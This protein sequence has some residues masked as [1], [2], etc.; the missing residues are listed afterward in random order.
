MAIHPPQDDILVRVQQR[1]AQRGITGAEAAS[2]VAK[3]EA[4]LGRVSGPGAGMQRAVGQPSIP[5]PR[6]EPVDPRYAKF[7]VDPN[8]PLVARGLKPRQIAATPE[9]IAANGMRFAAP[10]LTLVLRLQ[11][12]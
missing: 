6:G 1:L 2:I 9:D 4:K 12:Q 7:Q 11:G 10:E 5:T 3:I 8:D